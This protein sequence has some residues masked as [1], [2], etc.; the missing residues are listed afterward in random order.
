MATADPTP[1]APPATPS[2]APRSR[3]K[4]AGL[5][6]QHEPAF[7]LHAWPWRE[8]SLILDVFSR[9]HGRVG[10][11][12]KGAKRPTS[13]LRPVLLSFL[14][15]SAS[16]SG[17]AELKTLTAA[18]WMGGH[19]AL[20]GEALLGSFYLNEL[21]L[22]L[23]GREDPH[24]QLFDDYAEALVRL[25]FQP[26]EHAMRWFELR[27]LHELGHLPRLDQV[28]HNTT[29]VSDEQSYC[30]D[31]THGVHLGQGTRRYR[32]AL[33]RSIES[34]QWQDNGSTAEVSTLLSSLLGELMNLSTLKST[35]IMRL[36]SMH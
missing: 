29:P 6:I 12:A 35:H 5:R 31:L 19:A 3:K 20:T 32:G 23:L 33:L 7:V 11:V 36:C 22:K 18:E 34:G 10:L 25:R 1:L 2:A 4:A 13:K 27:L 30:V 16:W 21:L 28:S 17:R 8:T 24:P 15:F 26:V 14:P 9:H